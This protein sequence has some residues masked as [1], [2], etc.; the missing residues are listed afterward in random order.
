M[1]VATTALTLVL[2]MVSQGSVMHAQRMKRP[3]TLADSS[4]VTQLLYRELFHG[5]TLPPNEQAR[6]KRVILEA[7]KKVMTLQESDPCE[8]RRLYKTTMLSRDSVLLTM[9][10]TAADSAE[11][12]KRAAPMRPHGACPYR[13]DSVD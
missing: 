2:L 11:L 8:R 13:P 10:R 9:V 3:D 6:A 4:R 5:T 7:F 12:L 1:Q